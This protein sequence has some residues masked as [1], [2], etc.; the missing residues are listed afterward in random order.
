MSNELPGMIQLIPWSHRPRRLSG[1]SS[2]RHGRPVSLRPG[3]SFCIPP[4]PFLSSS[5]PL[6]CWGAGSLT[7]SRHIAYLPV[8]LC[9]TDAL[10]NRYSVST[11]FICIFFFKKKRPSNSEIFPDS[12]RFC[13]STH[14][15][16]GLGSPARPGL[17]GLVIRL[18]RP[19]RQSW[20]QVRSPRFHPRPHMATGD[21]GSPPPHRELGI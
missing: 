4:P 12:P 20:C 11:H 14:Y 2:H 10:G 6:S 1:H 9:F 15:T 16:P 7:R 21:P 8:V 17:V 18:G 19:S 3:I 5:Q 13:I